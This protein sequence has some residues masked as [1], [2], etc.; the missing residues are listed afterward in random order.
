MFTNDDPLNAADPTGLLCLWG[1][2]THGVSSGFDAIRHGTA[3]VADNGVTEVTS[4]YRGLTKIVI[5]GVT[6]VGTAACVAA[7]AGVCGALAFSVSG[8]EISGG[9]IAAGVAAG[10]VKGAADYA[11]DSGHHSL[12]GFFK[13]AA[14][15]GGEDALFAGLPEEAIFGNLGQ[16]AHSAEM[17]FSQSLT[18]L[19]SY[20][21]GA[22]KMGAHGY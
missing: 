7:T 12:S 13:S 15:G 21:A 2:I 22:F 8:F 14:I 16:G 18:F 5:A 19:P 4:H 1:C 20:L 3:H 10:G 6:I 11:L 9:A 17:T